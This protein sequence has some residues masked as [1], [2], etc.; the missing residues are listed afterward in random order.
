MIQIIVL[1]GLCL[2]C[3]GNACTRV[4]KHTHTHTHTHTVHVL[5]S[6]RVRARSVMWVKVR[7]CRCVCVCESACWRGANFFFCLYTSCVREYVTQGV[8]VVVVILRWST[9]WRAFRSIQ[10]SASFQ[11]YCSSLLSVLALGPTVILGVCSCLDLG[12]ETGRLQ[13]V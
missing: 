1:T 11:S 12:P 2:S 10:Q 7:L 5:V 6:V 3:T 9:S 8:L 4:C 13:H